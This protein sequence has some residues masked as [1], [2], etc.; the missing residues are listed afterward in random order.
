VGEA[1]GAAIELV[2]EAR[3]HSKLATLGERSRFDAALVLNHTADHQPGLTGVVDDHVEF[4]VS[5][6]LQNFVEVFDQLLTD[7]GKFA[8]QYTGPLAGEKKVELLR[9][10]A[11][12][13]AQLYDHVVVKAL[14]RGPVTRAKRL[15]VVSLVADARLPVELFYERKLPLPTAT[16]CPKAVEALRTGNCDCPEDEAV[17]CPMGFWGVTRVLERYAEVPDEF[18][19]QRP[20]AFVD[21]TD[22]DGWQ[23]LEVFRASV[24][25]WTHRVPQVVE[26][27]VLDAVVR[28]LTTCG[29]PTPLANEWAALQREVSAHQ[30]T[31]IVLL[32]H[33]R[34]VQNQKHQKAELGKESWLEVIDLDRRYVHPSDVAPQPLVLMLGCGTGSPL[35][36]FLGFAAKLRDAGAA[37]ALTAGAAIHGTHAVAAVEQFLTELEGLAA[38]GESCGEVMRRVRAKSLA[39][40]NLMVLSLSAFGDADRKL[41][42]RSRQ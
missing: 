6:Q 9:S 13:G 8:E 12:N 17:V 22:R 31:L 5:P 21:A 28:R 10:L 2:P 1:R 4:L 3:V 40:G 29:T 18:P 42:L 14:K 39:D 19:T 11:R 27:D 20:F 32:V 7:V 34:Q 26:Q 38:D 24:C 16:L 15:Q 37:I 33:T 23:E 35:V 25:G 41:V 30:P 36:D